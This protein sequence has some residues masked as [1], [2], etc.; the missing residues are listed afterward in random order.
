MKK[1][2]RLLSIEE[3]IRFLKLRINDRVS[4]ESIVKGE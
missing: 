4:I 1:G 3:Q 2:R